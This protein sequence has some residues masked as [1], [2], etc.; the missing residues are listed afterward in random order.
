MAEFKSADK[1]EFETPVFSLDKEIND[2]EH[3]QNRGVVIS[4]IKSKN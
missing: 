4:Q 3:K 2:L 1:L